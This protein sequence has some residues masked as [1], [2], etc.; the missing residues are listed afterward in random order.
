MAGLI[1]ESAFTS[2]FGVVVRF[3][4][5]PLDKFNILDNIQ[6]VKYPVLVIQGK[7]DDIL[8]FE[9]SEQLF[10]AINSHKLSLSVE[11]ANHNDLSS[12]AGEKYGKTFRE[13][14]DLVS[15]N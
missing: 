11:D 6:K 5:L 3:P 1:I 13:F 2:A 9:H 4:I 12:V 10:A 14:A 15:Q 8:P 7:L